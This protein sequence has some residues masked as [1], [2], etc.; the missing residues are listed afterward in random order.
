MPLNFEGGGSVQRDDL[1]RALEVQPHNSDVRVRLGGIDVDL[2]RTD[3]D[4]ERDAIVL[5]IHP[6]DL[7]DA[8]RV[9]IA[10]PW[11]RRR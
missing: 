3:Y 7:E 9:A 6:D 8:L 5:D 4:T 2:I 10:G 11:W 1:V